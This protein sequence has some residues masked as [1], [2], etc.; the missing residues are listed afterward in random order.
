MVLR[1]SVSDTASQTLACE[2]AEF[3]KV[4]KVE[5]EVGSDA[6]SRSAVSR[7]SL[8]NSLCDLIALH[9]LKLRSPTAYSSQL[10]IIFF[11]S[12]QS[13]CDMHPLG[14]NTVACT[15]VSPEEHLPVPML[16]RPVIDSGPTRLCMN[17]SHASF[18]SQSLDGLDP[19]SIHSWRS[20]LQCP[21]AA[22]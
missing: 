16:Q 10:P 17:V 14:A 5:L 20:A 9:P 22:G 12:V 4:E 2:N 21:S 1:Y 11:P 19:P 6:E 7:R 13:L 3:E 15:P 18:E 8:S